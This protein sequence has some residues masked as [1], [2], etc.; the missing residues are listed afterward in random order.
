MS[1]AASVRSDAPIKKEATHPATDQL[2]Y[3]LRWGASP[4]S[5]ASPA[6]RADSDYAPAPRRLGGSYMASVARGAA[7]SLST[8][9]AAKAYATGGTVS[10][11]GTA[12]V[13]R[14]YPLPGG[15]ANEAAAGLWGVARA[16]AQETAGR[17][18][19][20]A[21]DQC[22][23]SLDGLCGGG[24]S[25]GGRVGLSPNRPSLSLLILYQPAP[26]RRWTLGWIEIGAASPLVEY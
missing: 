21:L 20:T 16:Y 15:S 17:P 22:G 11:L 12:G 18:T 24:G 5:P 2:M 19:L 9:V 3:A 4:A 26:R 1:G 8:L 13:H 6:S 10:H 14:P 23:H 25:G 7:G